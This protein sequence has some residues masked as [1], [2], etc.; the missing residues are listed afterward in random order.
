MY[1]AANCYKA[2][3]DV[4]RAQKLYTSLM[5]VAGYRDRAESALADLKLAQRQQVAAKPKA[6]APA[7]QAPPPAAAPASP[8]AQASPKANSF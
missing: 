8:P 4:D 6:A 1:D 5:G 2:L 3:G 7:K